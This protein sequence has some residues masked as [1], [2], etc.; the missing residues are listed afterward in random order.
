MKAELK[1]ETK[2]LLHFKQLKLSAAI[3]KLDGLSPL[4]IM[5]KGYSFCRNSRGKIVRSV[6]NIKTG[7]LLELS[8]PDGR[9]NCRAEELKE[10]S[11]IE[12]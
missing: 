1:K 2:N 5:N 12:R 9:A 4:K 8:F 6:K 10:G 3:E 11:I 7:E